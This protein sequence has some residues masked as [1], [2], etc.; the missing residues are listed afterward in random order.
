MK[1]N[2]IRCF[3][4]ADDY[5]WHVL[6]DSIE[7]YFEYTKAYLELMNSS[8]KENHY[9]FKNIFLDEMEFRQ[10]QRNMSYQNRRYDQ[11]DKK[12]ENKQ[13]HLRLVE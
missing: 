10:I 7:E 1:T 2:L 11:K 8:K 12:L 13:A 5:K 3:V 6:T 4:I 9:F